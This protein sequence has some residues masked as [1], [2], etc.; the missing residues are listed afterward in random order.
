MGKKIIDRASRIKA[1]AADLDGTL[2]VARGSTLLEVEAVK[3]VR[4]LEESGI[5]VAI[6]TGNSLPVAAGVAKYLG[7]TGPVFAENGCTAMVNDGIEHLCTGRPPNELVKK[8]V[9]LGFRDSWQNMYRMHEVALIPARRDP[10]LVEEASR[11]AAEYGFRALWSGYA[12]HIQ[13]PGGGKA[14][15]VEFLASLLGADA[16][17]IAAIG[18]GENDVDMLRAAG[19]SAAPGDASPLAK[20]AADYVAKA[21]GGRGFAEFAMLILSARGGGMA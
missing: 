6:V 16:S 11:L 13:P 3:A 7:S 2:T 10:A 15:A 20:S 9:E 21:P 12:L 1:V 18:D 19:L 5:Q 14:R 4:M 17:V 8:I